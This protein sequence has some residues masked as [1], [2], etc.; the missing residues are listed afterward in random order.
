VANQGDA[1]ACGQVKIESVHG[2]EV[3]EV[4]TQPQDAED[5]GGG[6]PFSSHRGLTVSHQ[7]D[8]ASSSGGETG[9]EREAP[10]FLSDLSSVPSAGNRTCDPPFRKPLRNLR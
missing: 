10:R 5:G 3:A 1:F 6:S 4:P 7:L 9:D 8:A 2:G